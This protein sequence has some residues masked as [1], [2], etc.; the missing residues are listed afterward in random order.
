ML[1]STLLLAGSRSKQTPELDL[2]LSQHRWKEAF[3]RIEHALT[4]QS[5]SMTMSTRAD[6]HL[7]A[8]TAANQEY[9]AAF[10]KQQKHKQQ[11]Q[12]A[13]MDHTC[14][15][16]P[17]L[18]AAIQHYRFAL[19]PQGSGGLPFDDLRRG[20]AH[21]SL[22]LLYHVRGEQM[23]QLSELRLAAKLEAA[24]PQTQYQLGALLLELGQVDEAVQSLTAAV[25]ALAST[26]ADDNG[27]AVCTLAVAAMRVAS[28]FDF[29]SNSA[30]QTCKQRMETRQLASSTALFVG[31]AMAD[32]DSADTGT[33]EEAVRFL[34]VGLT[35]ES[36][37]A[38][39]SSGSSYELFT[40]SAFTS[41]SSSTEV[42]SP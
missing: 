28:S 36:E 12:Q 22:S 21:F 33:L 15:G 17:C 1:L 18:D 39:R 9:A 24:D 7:K 5:D 10:M 42:T 30:I 23:S 13:R 19:Q 2:L 4:A 20:K 26:G 8:A 27:R 3:Y 11:K 29:V 37:T 38:A 31:L 25:N 14:A 34:E 32:N 40:F 16:R 41:L 35:I 6:L